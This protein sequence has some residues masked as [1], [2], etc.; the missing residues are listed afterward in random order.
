MSWDILTERF[1]PSPDSA[2]SDVACQR[3][4]QARA[5]HWFWAY[6]I[7]AEKETSIVFDNSAKFIAIISLN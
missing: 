4:W 5:C 2:N 3:F 6:Y 1:S 7:I